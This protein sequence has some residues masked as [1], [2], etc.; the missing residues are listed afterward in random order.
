MN[1]GFLVVFL[2]I[3]LGAMALIF[4]NQASN[5]VIVA[6]P[7][8]QAAEP[9]GKG[10]ASGPDAGGTTVAAAPQP[11]SRPAPV[12]AKPETPKPEA[13]KPDMPKPEEP[14]PEVAVPDA[15]KPETPG[16][17][18][19]RPDMPKPEEPKPEVA[20]SVVPKPEAPMPETSK[21]GVPK[22]E[23]V[24][25]TPVTS[26]PETQV[27]PGGAQTKKSMTLVNVGLQFRGGG[28][29]LRIEADAPF[30]Y[31]TFALPSP[32]RYVIDFTG[33]WNNMRAPTVPSNNMIKAA[34]AGKQAGG[35]RL[36]FDMM[37]APR[38]HNVAWI[39]PTVLEIIIE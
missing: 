38:K 26:R 36:V 33:T 15:L 1:K 20:V 4:V 12:S 2:G 27:S 11:A 10:A 3:I 29:A 17:E 37:R 6:A 8:Q 18:A 13:P 35:P 19:S 24:A 7:G 28:M 34:R 9:E 5:P 14:K 16:P 31:R 39:S 22:P 32:D 30:S 23:A 21:P 25:M